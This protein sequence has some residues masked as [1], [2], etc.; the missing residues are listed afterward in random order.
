MKDKK[1]LRNRKTVE[2]VQVTHWDFFWVNRK[3]GKTWEHAFVYKVL[4]GKREGSKFV[5]SLEGWELAWEEVFMAGG[6][7]W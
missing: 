6:A 7:S 2:L 1:L 3:S 5:E 4:S